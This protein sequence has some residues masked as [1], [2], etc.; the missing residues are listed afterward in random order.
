MGT[1][2]CPMQGLRMEEGYMITAGGGGVLLR[3]LQ[4]LLLCGVV[5]GCATGP[6]GTIPVSGVPDSA[7]EEKLVMRT[8]ELHQKPDDWDEFEATPVEEDTP[9]PMTGYRDPTEQIYRIEAGDV[10]EFQSW[11]D[12][13]LNR[14][15]LTVRFDGHVSLPLIPDINVHRRTREEATEL[16]RQAYEEVFLEPQ[17][18]LR[19]VESMSK[20][21]YVM[22]SVNSPGEYAFRRTMNLLEAINNAGGQRIDRRGGDSFAGEQGQ[23]AKAFIIRIADEDRYVLEYD[24]RNLSRPGP[25]AS[26]APVIPGDVVYVPEGVNLVYV[27]GMVGRQGVYPISEGTTMLRLLIQAGGPSFTTGQLRNVVLMRPINPDETEIMLINVRQLLRGGR[28]ILIEPGDTIYVPQRRLV[29]LS[30]FI[31]QFVGTVSPVMNLY[32][33][34]VDTRYHY[35]FVKNRV[36][37]IRDSGQL[38]NAALIDLLVG[39]TPTTPLPGGLL[40]PLP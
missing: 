34:A 36:D 18:S 16:I 24:L 8:D 9:W 30:T 25:H 27:I 11:D 21:Y 26:T 31:N 12:P 37:Q 5:A 2:P 29:R 23:L 17:V 39:F 13:G 38:S 7:V 4:V 35:E 32:R 40:S 15:G 19:I 33:Q 6:D 14:N 28:D 10:L 20:S 22:G 3:R 1:K